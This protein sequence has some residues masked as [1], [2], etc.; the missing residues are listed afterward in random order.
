MM[1]E[2]GSKAMATSIQSPDWYKLDNAAKIYPPAYSDQAPIAFRVGLTLKDPVRYDALNTALLR[3]IKRVPYYQVHLRRGLFWYYLQRHETPPSIE[4]LGRAP[5]SRIRMRSSTEQLFRVL[6]RDRRIRIDFSHVLTDGVGGFKFLATLTAEYL[7]QLGVHV[8]PGELVLDPEDHPD[9]AEFTDAYPELLV[10]GTPGP[11]PL[12]PAY[13][14]PWP[15]IPGYHRTLTG[16]LS[17]DALS[18][19]AREAGAS[20]TEYLVSVYIHAMFQIWRTSQHKPRSRR[21]IRVEVPVDLRRLH[22]SATM[23]N[24]SL[25]VLPEIDL[26]LGHI[27]FPDIVRTVHH[28]M[29]LQLD[30]RSLR[31]QI[32]RNVGGENLA[33][34]RIIPLILKDWYL[35][36]LHRKFGT[37]IYSGVVSNL[38]L[39]KL[40]DEMIEHVVDASFVLGPNPKLRQAVSIIG[41]N[42]SVN[43]TIGS[44]VESRELERLYFSHIAAQGVAVRV[45]EQVS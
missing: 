19:V 40:P 10:P 21:V 12:R 25:F 22:P 20:I 18:R 39:V 6:V 11:D 5:V 14:L 34:V 7:R 45:S 44:V 4:V 26:R 2:G 29:R 30:M 3:T 38:G 13:H 8:P 17:V 31:R 15:A 41:Y 37:D 1:E 16:K 43:V 28:S 42:G 9:A 32:A 33:L 35:P 24:F 36:S 23:R 27:S